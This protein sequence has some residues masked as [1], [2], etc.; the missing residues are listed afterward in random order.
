MVHLLLSNDC[1]IP[2]MVA[3]VV[4]HV[5]GI[6]AMWE[7]ARPRS[8]LVAVLVVRG[9]ADWGDE[10]HALADQ[11]LAR[12]LATCFLDLLSPIHHFRLLCVALVEA[13][14]TVAVSV[15]ANGASRA[16]RRGRAVVVL[17]LETIAAEAGHVLA[18]GP[19][20]EVLLPS[21]FSRVAFLV[22]AFEAQ[23]MLKLRVHSLRLRTELMLLCCLCLA[24]EGVVLHRECLLLQRVAT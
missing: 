1:P 23:L 2:N 7:L 18:G 17:S 10:G 4:K 16:H 14:L 15:T 24:L 3:A 5:K 9:V 13:D 19:G 12:I 22:I 21:P 6:L 11:V 8:T 20:G